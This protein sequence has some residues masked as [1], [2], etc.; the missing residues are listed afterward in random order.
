[1]AIANMD[2][3][4]TYNHA[5]WQRIF[6]GAGTRNVKKGP[7]Q[8]QSETLCDPQT[9][10]GKVTNLKFRLITLSIAGHNATLDDFNES[11]CGAAMSSSRCGTRY[12]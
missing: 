7:I 6:F 4:Q 8:T 10:P 2:T 12:R 9:W 11:E 1:M 5:S 3:K